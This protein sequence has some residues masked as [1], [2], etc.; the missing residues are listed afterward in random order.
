MLVRILGTAEHRGGNGPS[1][2]LLGGA[3]YQE[4]YDDD[5]GDDD[6]DDD[7]DDLYIMVKCMF[8]TKK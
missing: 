1:A 8:V 7:D 6:D 4:S 5:D 3:D 2:R